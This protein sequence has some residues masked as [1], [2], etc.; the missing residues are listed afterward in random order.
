MQIRKPVDE[1]LKQRCLQADMAAEAELLKSHFNI[2]T[3]C[4]MLFVAANIALRAGL[5]AGWTIH[6]IATFFRRDDESPDEPSLLEKAIDEARRSAR[7]A[8]SRYKQRVEMGQTPRIQ[9]AKKSCS[10]RCR[11]S[12]SFES[13]LFRDIMSPKRLYP[14][15]KYRPKPDSLTPCSPWQDDSISS[16]ECESEEVDAID[17]AAYQTFFIKY[18]QSLIS[19]Q[20]SA[21]V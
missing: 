21:S 18:A 7:R 6:A 10:Q 4:V 12:A 16:L 8:F 9:S 20:I 2:R 15:S 11:K 14:L 1:T 3:V 17:D 13:P 5:R 19:S